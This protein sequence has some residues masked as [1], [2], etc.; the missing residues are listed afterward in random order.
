MREERRVPPYRAR[1]RRGP[2]SLDP[3]LLYSATASLVYR[4]ID[5]A[6]VYNLLKGIHLSWK[7]ARR[8]ADALH[9]VS[10]GMHMCFL[11]L[12]PNN[13]QREMVAIV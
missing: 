10:D 4:Y 1:Y 12:I 13:G 9:L 7:V 5:T 2:R 3:L 6:G 8:Y 11:V